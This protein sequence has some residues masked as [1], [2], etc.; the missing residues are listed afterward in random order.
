M[1]FYNV[2]DFEYLLPMDF[3]LYQ[4]S[5]VLVD[6]DIYWTRWHILGHADSVLGKTNY[7]NLNTDK[8][9]LFH[10]NYI[11]GSQKSKQ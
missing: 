10:I 7:S 8:L 4:S 5:F 1:C 6:E 9:L 3:A 2:F 11:L